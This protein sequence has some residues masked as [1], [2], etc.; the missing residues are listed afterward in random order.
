MSTNSRQLWIATRSCSKKMGHRVK[1]SLQIV[2]GMLH[3]QASSVHDDALRAHL[4]EASGRV[5][6]IGRAYE[7]LIV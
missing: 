1:N 7:R 5:S 3:L 6:A 4:A 2:S